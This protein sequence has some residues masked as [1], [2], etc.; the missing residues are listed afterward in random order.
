[1]Q[2][3]I[4]QMAQILLSEGFEG[5]MHTYFNENDPNHT[6]IAE[7]PPDPELVKRLDEVTSFNQFN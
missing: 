3:Q 2:P 6:Y 5:S 1:M 7:T 4:T